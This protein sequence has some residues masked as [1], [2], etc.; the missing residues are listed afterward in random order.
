MTDAN[1]QV[2]Q[3]EGLRKVYRRRGRAHRA[4][5]GLDL[6]VAAGQV[7]GFLGPNGSGK[8]TTLRALLGL[9]RADGGT[10]R[11]F[12]EPVPAALPE[13]IGAV[14]AVV[15]SPQFF[16]NFTA[17]RTLRLLATAGRVRRRRVDEVLEIVGLRDR[18][19][20]RVRSFS[21]GMKQRLAIA[22]ALLKSPQVLILDEPANGL[23]PAGI[24]EIR[25][26]LRSLGASGM[27]VLL[28][29]H[30]LSEVQ[31]ICDHVSIISLGRQ[32]VSGPVSEV[33]SQF[34]KGDVRVRVP[35]PRAAARIIGDT[36]LPVQVYG[37]HLVVSDLADPAWITE[38]LAKRRIYVSE[39]TPLMPDLENVFLRLTETM[40][41]PGVRRQ[42]D[43]A[44]RPQ[45]PTIVPGMPPPSG[46][47]PAP[48]AEPRPAEPRP[49]E[50]P[51][52]EQPPGDPQPA[53]ATAPGP[54]AEAGPE[55]PTSGT[56]APVLDKP[57]PGVTIQ[58]G[59]TIQL[60]TP[61]SAQPE[62]APDIEAA[63]P[64]TQASPEPV[65]E[66]APEPVADADVAP[67]ATPEAAAKTGDD[68]AED[69]VSGDNVTGENVT[70]E[71][72][73][74]AAV[75]EAGGTTKTTGGAPAGGEGETR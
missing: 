12:G 3:I 21:L 4:L 15:E 43:D 6:S 9:V 46:P 8:T 17:R 35:D 13:V 28:S 25:D 56:E 54:T 65:A 42:V 66:T 18:A 63:E 11:I 52:A 47:Q 49:A 30:I 36:G 73:A 14:G 48:S 23:D 5:D 34:D 44:Y 22:S 16:G 62:I 10:M 45:A 64:A 75:A 60:E 40:P 61:A 59:T 68:A 41:K 24:R 69:D 32:V 51:P 55:Q 50:P 2:I 57:A 74:A 1:G 71:D 20:D 72:V 58:P 29:S 39:L 31:Q 38:T 53:P 37:D 7:H 26:L 67:E 70:G 19:K 33:L 27:T